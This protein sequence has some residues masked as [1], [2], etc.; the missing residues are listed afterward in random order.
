MWYKEGLLG[1]GEAGDMAGRAGR[2]EVV[3]E[4]AD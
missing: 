2:E 4:F 1:L 3:A